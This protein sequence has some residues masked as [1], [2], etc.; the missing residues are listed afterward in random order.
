MVTDK[1]MCMSVECIY[2]Q[3]YKYNITVKCMY[4]C[5]YAYERQYNAYDWGM[6]K[7]IDLSVCLV[8]TIPKDCFTSI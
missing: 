4:V 5:L 2:P 3:E 7:S 1:N 6:G 8:L